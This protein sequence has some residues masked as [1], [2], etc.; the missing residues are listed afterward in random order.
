MENKNKIM[1]EIINL[2]LEK[3]SAE[4]IYTILNSRGLKINRSTVQ[5]YVRQI[6]N[7]IEYKTEITRTVFHS[8]DKINNRLEDCCDRIEK[9]LDFFDNLS[10][11]EAAKKTF[12]WNALMKSLVSVLAGTR[13]DL[14]RAKEI[15]KPNAQNVSYNQINMIISEK[16]H[17]YLKNLQKLGHITIHNPILLKEIEKIS[18]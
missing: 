8:I 15:S 1:K 7:E 6:P 14:R 5:K 4:K 11:K 9:K 16:N 17:E 12:E 13:D 2:H 18:H 10:P 3:N